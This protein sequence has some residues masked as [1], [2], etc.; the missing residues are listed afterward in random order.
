[1]LN[2]QQKDA[3]LRLARRTLEDQFG[4]EGGHPDAA[5]DSVLD[6]PE[7]RQLRGV[8]VTLTKGGQLRG[9][10]G[11]L[12]A[13]SPLL[14]EVVRQTIHAALHD[15][16]FPVLTKEE[17]PQ[18]RIEISVLTPP[19]PM[20]YADADELVRKLRPG[21]DGVI[22]KQRGGTGATFLPQVWTELPETEVFLD[23]LCR[24]ARLPSQS[25]RKGRLI[26]HTYQAVHFSEE[27]MPVC[28]S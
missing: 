2:Q 19:T 12:L 22:L 26:V 1:M 9:C 17:L 6:A 8:F 15:R 3:L 10:I 24:K 25:W 21:I 7:L 14:D 27:E 13:V 11:S 18:I 23:Y 5:A 16:R 28:R 4:I 20:I